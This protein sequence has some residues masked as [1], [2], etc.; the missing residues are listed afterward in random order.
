[1]KAYGKNKRITP[2]LLILGTRYIWSRKLHTQA[3]LRLG[4]KTVV[5]IE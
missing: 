3:P 2:L 4:K 1:M 5:F